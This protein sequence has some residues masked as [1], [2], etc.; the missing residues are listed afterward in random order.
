M[1]LALPEN[2]FRFKRAVLATP[3]APPKG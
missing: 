1:D 2:A 3:E